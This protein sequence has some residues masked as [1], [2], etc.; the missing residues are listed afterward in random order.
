MSEM[1]L[2]RIKGEMRISSN[3]TSEQE[4]EGQGTRM[5]R[6][7]VKLIQRRSSSRKTSSVRRT[8]ESTRGS[9]SQEI[10]ANMRSNSTR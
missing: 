10:E 2:R 3:T 9:A 8:R 5:E 4:S 6:L 1:R 7:R